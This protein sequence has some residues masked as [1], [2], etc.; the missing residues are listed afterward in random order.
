MSLPLTKVTKEDVLKQQAYILFY[1]RR[2]SDTPSVVVTQPGVAAA[3]AVKLMTGQ[4]PALSA[5][6]AIAAHAAGTA[7]ADTRKVAAIARPVAASLTSAL[8]AIDDA[9]LPS[10]RRTQPKAVL[11]AAGA[12]SRWEEGRDF[13]L[14]QS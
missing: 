4:D 10:A 8:A 5:T 6:A 13:F 2:K 7:A 9:L 1:T 14:T 11:A 12:D 3:A